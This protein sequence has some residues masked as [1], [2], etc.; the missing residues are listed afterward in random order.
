LIHLDVLVFNSSTIAANVIVRQVKQQVHVIGHAVDHKRG[1]SGILEYGRRV[2]VQF[3]F[4]RSVN[5]R[6][7][8][9]RA[10]HEMD[11]NV[12]Q[13]LGHFGTGGHGV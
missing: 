10:E 8:V 7:A 4:Q 6:L 9:L 13:R 12:R 2:G 5:E 1:A 3:G 11:Q